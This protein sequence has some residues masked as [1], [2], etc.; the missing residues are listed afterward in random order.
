[1]PNPALQI[2]KRGGMF[3]PDDYWRSLD[4]DKNSNPFGMS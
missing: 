3:A 1:M 2:T 4:G